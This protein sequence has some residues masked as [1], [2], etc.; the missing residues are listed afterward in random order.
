VVIYEGKFRFINGSRVLNRI[1]TLKFENPGPGL[2]KFGKGAES[3]SESDSGH[4]WSGVGLKNVRL[5]TRLGVTSSVANLAFLKPGC[6][7]L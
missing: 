7:N 1:R 2:K 3:V 4:L 5:L 6:E